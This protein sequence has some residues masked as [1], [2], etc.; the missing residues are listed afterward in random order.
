[1]STYTEWDDDLN[2]PTSGYED[3]ILIE[4]GVTLYIKN[5]P[6]EMN[7]G[8]YIDI[9]NGGKLILENVTIEN[10]SS[11]NWG[12]IR[13]DGDLTK[14]QFTTYPDPEEEN[15]EE[16]W[17]GEL[18]NDQTQ[19]LVTNSTFYNADIAITS[20]YGAIVRCENSDFIDNVVGV[21]FHTYTNPDPNATI[22]VPLDKVNASYIIGCDFEWTI[23]APGFVGI[24]L[25]KVHGVNIGGCTFISSDMTKRCPVDKPTG[26]LGKDADFS[27]STAG[28]SMC[29][30]EMGC[31]INCENETPGLGCSFTNLFHGIKLRGVHNSA[32]EVRHSEFKDNYK[33]IYID[34]DIFQNSQQSSIVVMNCEF[35]THETTINNLFDLNPLNCVLPVIGFKS[36][37]EHISITQFANVIYNN[38]FNHNGKNI[39][40]VTVNKTSGEGHPRSGLIINNTFT[41]QMS[42]SVDTDDVFGIRANFGNS[43]QKVTCNTFQEMGTDIK[44]LVGGS[45]QNPMT[46][47]EGYPHPAGN[48]FS[49]LLSGRYRI[50]NGGITLEYLW[51]SSNPPLIYNPYGTPT[52]FNVNPISP[53]TEDP[54]CEITCEDIKDEISFEWPASAHFFN[55]SDLLLVYP[56]PA[57]HL[58]YIHLNSGSLVESIKIINITGVTVYNQSSVNSS[59][60]EVDLTHL[61]SGLYFVVVEDSQNIKYTKKIIIEN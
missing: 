17:A 26:I 60:I 12:G 16:A 39:A 13:A 18:N 35:D 15:D 19:V 59:S 25:D 50:D 54:E 46:G 52:S 33:G 34:Q 4:S 10:S 37:I 27:V 1:V 28:N 42:G 61:S 9:E 8:K 30:D 49:A 22:D 41:N 23:H 53:L 57:R 55:Y 14:T 29:Y 56:N 36:L 20:K 43:M 3:G 5:L 48:R 58:L 31:P 7:P 38:T 6:L 45:L 47:K 11:S 44:I 24:E 32:I 51:N 2:Q 40:Y 21:Y